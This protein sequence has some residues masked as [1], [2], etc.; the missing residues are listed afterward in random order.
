LLQGTDGWNTYFGTDKI[1]T[2]EYDS[3]GKPG[4]SRE[5]L[6]EVVTIWQGVAS[7][8]ALWDVD[9]TTEDPGPEGIER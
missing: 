1:I 8:F 6:Q 9:V 2:P 4:F 7:H 5:E 3:D